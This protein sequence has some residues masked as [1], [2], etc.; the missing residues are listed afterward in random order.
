[1]QELSL[2]KPIT[3]FPFFV[4]HE[5]SPDII[6]CND[7]LIAIGIIPD[8]VARTIKWFHHVIDWK[9]YSD[10]PKAK[11]NLVQDIYLSSYSSSPIEIKEAKYG[12]VE[13]ELVAA[14]Q[15][16]LSALKQGKLAHVLGMLLL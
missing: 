5:S 11:F 12:K 13:P 6:L 9:Q 14:Q 1:L 7:F 16:H 4:T 2:S 8:S 15:K 10:L 3:Y